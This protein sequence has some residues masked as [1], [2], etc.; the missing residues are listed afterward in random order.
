M[1]HGSY[2]DPNENRFPRLKSKLVDRW[3]ECIV[4]RFPTPQKQSLEDW[5]NVFSEYVKNIDSDTIL[6]GHSLGV[7][8]ILSIL[9]KINQPVKACFLIAWFCESLGD[10]EF[11]KVNKSFVD[12]DFNREKIKK[13]CFKFV[14]FHSDDDPYVPLVKAKNLAKRIFSNFVFVP[15]AGHFNIDSGYMDF[16]QLLEMIKDETTDDGTWFN[17]EFLDGLVDEREEF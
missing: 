2:G 13:N 17:K 15:G 12:R 7:A 9:E 14:Q 11:D 16:P 1:I 4:P 3:F 5:E 10:P 8:F 6:V